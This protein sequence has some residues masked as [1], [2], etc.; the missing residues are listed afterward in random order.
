MNSILFLKWVFHFILELTLLFSNGLFRLQLIDT[1]TCVQK[2]TPLT[3]PLI[4]N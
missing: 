4:A 2:S 1:W 3:L